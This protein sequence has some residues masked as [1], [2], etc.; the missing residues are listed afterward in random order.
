MVIPYQSGYQ[1]NN[2][3]D[4]DDHQNND[5]TNDG[6][7][8]N[9]S[10]T[11]TETAGNQLETSHGDEF[12]DFHNEQRQFR[13]LDR[14]L[15]THTQVDQIQQAAQQND[16]LGQLVG[17]QQTHGDQINNRHNQQLQTPAPP[18]NLQL[19]PRKPTQNQSIHNP[20]T[21]SRLVHNLPVLNPINGGIM[22]RNPII[23]NQDVGSL[24]SR[25]QIPQATKIVPRP[26]VVPQLRPTDNELARQEKA[27][28][29]LRE[30][31]MREL[32]NQQEIL[33]LGRKEYENTEKEIIKLRKINESRKKKFED[34]ER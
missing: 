27:Q 32:S 22:N 1:N 14:N 16:D 19:Q 9:N 29:E 8:Q 7:N 11:D 25:C 30:F 18:I 10:T 12:D 20:I 24:G 6:E 15:V 5:T 3:I 13:E 31:R 21:G 4:D 28:A 17:V 2:I 33:A 26:Y 34:A 23:R